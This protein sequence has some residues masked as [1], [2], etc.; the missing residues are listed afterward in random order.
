MRIS[1]VNV[2]KFAENCGFACICRRNTYWKP[3]F[4]FSFNSSTLLHF[5]QNCDMRWQHGF[6]FLNFLNTWDLRGYITLR[7]DRVVWWNLGMLVKLGSDVQHHD[8][9]ISTSK[10]FCYHK[11]FFCDAI[12]LFWNWKK[13]FFM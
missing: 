13:S 1:S 9:N 6:S 4:L 10:W 5:W 3:S 8:T 2:T 12:K 11:L 7:W